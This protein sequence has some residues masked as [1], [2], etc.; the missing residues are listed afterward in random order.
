[1][2]SQGLFSVQIQVAGMAAEKSNPEIAREK[3][4]I[5]AGVGRDYNDDAASP[6]NH[7]VCVRET[8]AGKEKLW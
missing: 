5:D 4:R 1:M 8:A 3:K 6:A 7:D 2:T